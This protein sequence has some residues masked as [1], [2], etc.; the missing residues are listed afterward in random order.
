MTSDGKRLTFNRVKP[1]EDVYLAEFFPKGPR[2]S[3]PRR[4]TLDD[5]DDLPFDWTLDNKAV[6]FTSNR[7]GTIN[8][9]RQKIDETSAEMLVFG[10]EQKTLCRLNP[11]GTQILYLVPTSASDYSRPV[12]LLRASINGGPPQTVLEAPGISNHQC[13]RAR[14]RQFASLANRKQK[15]SCFQPLTQLAATHTR[16]RSWRKRLRAG[17][18]VSRRM[19]VS[20]QS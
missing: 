14:R 20:L 1:Q 18:G 13:S 6:L 3:T 2:I 5:A 19:E 15:S 16:W 17:T 7:T 10:P 12:R 8:I 4:L 11:D 9:F